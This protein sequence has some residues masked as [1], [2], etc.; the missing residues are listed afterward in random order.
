[1][2]I[3]MSVHMSI[4]M[5]IHMS[6]HMSIHMSV[7]MPTHMSI[8]MSVHMPTHIAYTQVGRQSKRLRDYTTLQCIMGGLGMTP[9]YAPYRHNYVGP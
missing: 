3:H 7:H 8:H 6:V 2:S 5:S 4:H 1:M 9:V